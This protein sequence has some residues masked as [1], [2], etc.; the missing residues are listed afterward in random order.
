MSGTIQEQVSAY[1]G[2]S[3]ADWPDALYTTV[4]AV[5]QVIGF[6][7]DM[8]ADVVEIWLKY[9]RGEVMSYIAF[10]EACDKES[11]QES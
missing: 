6:S 1:M 10:R 7:G 3:F 9:G 11:E 2:M 5:S 4:E 8:C